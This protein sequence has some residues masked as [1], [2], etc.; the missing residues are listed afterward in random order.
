M[1]DEMMVTVTPLPDRTVTFEQ[2]RIAYPCSYYGT[3]EYVREYGAR[4]D[5]GWI[6]NRWRHD[7]VTDMVYEI[8]ERE[9]QE[10]KSESRVD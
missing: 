10:V 6:K 2:V 5:A 3:K 1:S 4:K 9:K 7:K 8:W